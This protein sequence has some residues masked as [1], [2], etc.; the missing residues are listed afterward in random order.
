MLIT[1]PPRTRRLD[2]LNLVIELLGVADNLEA[3]SHLFDEGAEHLPDGKIADV[4]NTVSIHIGRISD[5][6]EEFA[7]DAEAHRKESEVKAS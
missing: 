5:D 2:L 4:L 1:T 7:V 3:L 6:I